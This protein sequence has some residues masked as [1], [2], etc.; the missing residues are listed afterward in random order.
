ME[1]VSV[2]FAVGLTQWRD[3][4]FHFPPSLES[5]VPQSKPSAQPRPGAHFPC[6]WCMRPRT[7]PLSLRF[8]ALWSLFW[9]NYF[10]SPKLC[11]PHLDPLFHQIGNEARSDKKRRPKSRFSTCSTKFH[12]IWLLWLDVQLQLSHENA[13]FVHIHFYIFLEKLETFLNAF[14]WVLLMSSKSRLLPQAMV[15]HALTIYASV[16]CTGENCVAVLPGRDWLFWARAALVGQAA[17]FSGFS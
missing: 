16:L 2:N 3:P 9:K 17:A 8:S 13:Y 1:M 7:R 6:P 15:S 5:C 11:P 14:W 12:I 4:H 10:Q